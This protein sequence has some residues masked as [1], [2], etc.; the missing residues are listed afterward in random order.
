MAIELEVK[1]AATEQIL[2]Q[3]RSR[4]CHQSR[5]IAMR[6]TYYDTPDGDLS[7]RWFTLRQR[8]ENGESVCTLKIPAQEGRN[9]FEVLC[10]DIFSALPELCKLSGLE[11]PQI[12][13]KGLVPV[14]AAQFTRIAQDIPFGESLLE[15]ALDQGQL[16]GGGK[17]VPL[18]EVEVELKQGEP[19]A[20][21]AFAALLQSSYPLKPEKK[22]KFRRAL[23]LAKG[24]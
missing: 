7:A 21:A 9:E 22:S 18:C 2:Q 23:S 5:Q 12:A 24:E 14:C 13:E 15:L 4:F 17:S 16:M 6:T 19:A 3:L 10:G 11:L 1:F 8:Q 20:L